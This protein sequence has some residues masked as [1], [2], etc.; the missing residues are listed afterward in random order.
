MRAGRTTH[1]RPWSPFILHVGIRKMLRFDSLER[2]EESNRFSV[3]AK[4][5]LEECFSRAKLEVW[6]EIGHQSDRTLDILDTREEPGIRPLKPARE[7]QIR[8]P[9][10]RISPSISQW[11][12]ANALATRGKRPKCNL[13]S[14]I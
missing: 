2:N 8:S 3:T 10:D 7:T 5:K 9:K 13:H 1:E 6:H 4:L 14:T 12:T 11:R